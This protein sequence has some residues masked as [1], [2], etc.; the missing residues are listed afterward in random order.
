M[1]KMESWNLFNAKNGLNMKCQKQSMLI[2]KNEVSQRNNKL[3]DLTI[4]T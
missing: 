1:F 4:L 3:T 2:E